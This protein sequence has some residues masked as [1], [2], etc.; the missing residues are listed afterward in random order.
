MGTLEFHLTP[1]DRELIEKAHRN[2]PLTP[3]E[4][5]RFDLLAAFI[6]L[7]TQFAERPDQQRSADGYGIEDRSKL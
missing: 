6:N 3:D 7:N 4:Q 5:E 1:A 2:H